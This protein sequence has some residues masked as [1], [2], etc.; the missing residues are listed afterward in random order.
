[1]PTQGMIRFT[2]MVRM[3]RWLWWWRCW[4]WWWWWWWWWRWWWWWWCPRRWW[5]GSPARSDDEDDDDQMRR[6]TYMM[7]TIGWQF[8]LQ[9]VINHYRPTHSVEK[10]LST[11]LQ[12]EDN[13]RIRLLKEM[14]VRVWLLCE[15]LQDPCQDGIMPSSIPKGVL[16]HENHTTHHLRWTS[17]EPNFLIIFVVP[18]HSLYHLVQRCQFL[19]NFYLTAWI[20]FLIP[21]CRDLHDIPLCGNVKVPEK[22]N[23]WKS[24]END[25]S[26][27]RKVLTKG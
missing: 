3:F 14:N 2:C 12:R 18:H 10:S 17:T 8:S 15:K 5:S 24:A 21:L 9:Q 25:I 11:E 26:A 27:W 4:W 20:V 6:F 16:C 7:I 19:Y 1:M 13:I 23:N 22:I